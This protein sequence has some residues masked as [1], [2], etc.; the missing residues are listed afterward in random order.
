MSQHVSNRPLAGQTILLTRPR[1][2]AGELRG[3]LERLGARVISFPTIE[4]QPVPKT[5][6]L[7]R[8]IRGISDFDFV[9]FTSANGVSVFGKRLRELSIPI[10]ACGKARFA[11]IGSKTA[12]KLSALG[13]KTS[14]LPR[15]FTSRGLLHAFRKRKWIRGKKFLLLRTNIAPPGL[16]KSLE[17]EGGCTVEIPVYRTACR[18]NG[19][20]R[21]KAILKKGVGYVVFTSSSTVRGFFG[22]LS[23][24]QL[25]ESRVI[26]IGPVTSE[27]VR[28]FGARVFRQASPHNAQGLVQALIQAERKG[29]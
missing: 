28:R 13:I 3:E 21:L 14:L 5:P 2:Q 16:R 12:E 29:K 17:K 6:A 4:I 9:I 25:R 26:S 27:A 24:K 8:A 20:N 10:S 7:E 11:A 19:R 22:M 23:F 15:E 1:S 18:A